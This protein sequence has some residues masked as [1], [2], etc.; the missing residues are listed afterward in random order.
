MDE[1]ARRLV[2]NVAAMRQLTEASIANLN[3][4]G[5]SNFG[6]KTFVW[7]S[8]TQAPPSS[9]FSFRL[10]AR[11]ELMGNA[12]KE[13]VEN[14]P[15]AMPSPKLPGRTHNRAQK[16]QTKRAPLTTMRAEANV[17]QSVRDVSQQPEAASAEKRAVDD[18][19]GANGRCRDTA[20]EGCAT[21]FEGQSRKEK[22]APFNSALL[23]HTGSDANKVSGQGEPDRDCDSAARIHRGRS[24][25][26]DPS[27]PQPLPLLTYARVKE[28][29][30]CARP[31]PAFHN[32]LV[33]KSG[34]G[35]DPDDNDITARRR[36]FSRSYSTSKPTSVLGLRKLRTRGVR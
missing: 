33:P 26:N 32:P 18:D 1:R 6:E 11:H 14:L 24:A 28:P 25:A 13:N 2:D 36:R 31:M 22:Y 3:A 10:R 7:G 4:T 30:A 9:T 35:N 8:A 21:G 12:D 16:L 27:T 19:D 23:H 5:D 15:T 20:R 29:N 34:R 17:A